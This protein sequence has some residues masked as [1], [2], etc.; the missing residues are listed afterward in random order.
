MRRDLGL[1]NGSLPLIQVKSQSQARPPGKI[2]GLGVLEDV[3]SV[4]NGECHRGS[5]VHV[6]NGANRCE[7]GSV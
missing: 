5:V 6:L 3:A 1:M 7:N 2:K 4:L